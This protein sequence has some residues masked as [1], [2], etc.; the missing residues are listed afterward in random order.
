MA[1]IDDVDAATAAFA[2]KVPL[3]IVTRGSKGAIGVE[4]GRRVEVPAVWIETVVDTT[5]AGDLFA[6]GVLMGQAKG[7]AL[8]DSLKIGANAAAEVISH[9]GARPEIDLRGLLA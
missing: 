9:F 6:A 3:L 5:G 1:G 7:R 2:D 4:H 8:G